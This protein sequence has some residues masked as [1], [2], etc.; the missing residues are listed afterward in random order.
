MKLNPQARVAVADPV[1]QRVFRETATQVNLLTEGRVSAVQNAATSV[2]TTEL[3]ARGDF[4]LNALPSELGSASS[5]YIIHGWRC[6]LGG[7]P[8]T[9][10]ECRFLTGN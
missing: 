8:G 10:V 6:V 2:P 3:N 4:R 1:L 9:W 5:R 7:T